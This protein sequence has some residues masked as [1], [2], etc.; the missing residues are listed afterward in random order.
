MSSLW[1]ILVSRSRD[2]F[3]LFFPERCCLPRVLQETLSFIIYIRLWWRECT[4]D[5][6]LEASSWLHIDILPTQIIE[7]ALARTAYIR[8]LFS[9]FLYTFSIHHS[10]LFLSTGLSTS[11]SFIFPKYTHTMLL[12]VLRVI[13]FFD[14]TSIAVTSQLLHFYLW[15][16]TCYWIQVHDYSFANRPWEFFK[17]WSSTFLYFPSQ[18]R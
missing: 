12:K 7:P 4:K 16:P 13:C 9:A 3:S 15:Y 10:T 6:W 18:H 2:P 5:L 17:T 11:R 8:I 14:C 1:W